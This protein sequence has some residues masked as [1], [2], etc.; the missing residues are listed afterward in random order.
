MMSLSVCFIQ[1]IYLRS[2][3]YCEVEAGRELSAVAGT[4]CS[5]G[6]AVGGGGELNSD[7]ACT[8]RFDGYPPP[9][10]AGR[11]ES[12][13][14]SDGSTGH[15]ERVVAQRDV[16]ERKCSLN[17]RSNVNWSPLWVVGTFSV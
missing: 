3:G 10:V 6:V 5:S 16:A 2:P 14:L 7:P 1:W 12:A 4:N 11:V 15:R 8:C 9:Y 17:C 13:R